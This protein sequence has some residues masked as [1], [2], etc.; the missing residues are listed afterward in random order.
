MTNANNQYIIQR[1]L[2]EGGMGTVYLAEDTM[3]ER[4]VA[5]KELNKSNS[6]A[7][8]PFGNRFQQEA[9]ALARLN[10]PNITHLYS[11]LPKDDTWWMVMEYVQG[12]TLEEWLHI[13]KKMS[14]ALACSIM[15]QIL[16][17]LHHAHRKGIIHRDLKPA[18]VMISEDG[19]V[20]I[21]DFGIARI[22]NSQR[23]TQLGKSVGTLEY[24][25]P[26]QIQGKEGDERTDVYAAGTILYELLCGRPP[27]RAD[28]DYHLMRSKLEEVPEMLE[29]IATAPPA[30]QK[31]IL[32]ALERQPDKRFQDVLGFKSEVQNLYPH[33]L[34]EQAIISGLNNPPVAENQENTATRTITVKKWTPKFSIPTSFNFLPQL[35]FNPRRFAASLQLPKP[36]HLKNIRNLDLRNIKEL[37]LANS[38]WVLLGVIV[39]CGSLILWHSFSD[40]TPQSLVK[41]KDQKP[42]IAKPGDTV[43]QKASG[44]IL[45]NQ[46]M[47]PVPVVN[48]NPAPPT[49]QEKTE[50]EPADTDGKKKGGSSGKKKDSDKKENRVTPP[51]AAENE[52]EPTPAPE[53]KKETRPEHKGPVDIPAGREINMI[54][55]ETISSEDPGRDGDVVRL[56]AG[57]DIQSE[58]RI[59]IKK[60]ALIIGK[61]VDVVPS[62]KRKKGLIGFVAQK[63][64]ASNGT[65]IRLHSERFRLFAENAGMAA[66]YRQGHVFSAKLGRGRLD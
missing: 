5:I 64:E 4:L 34:R 57:E 56:Y 41:D 28:T 16:E 46:F 31:I 66:V 12:K 44:E 20:K 8:E 49:P 40:D 54:L 59:I 21:M 14:P 3:L 37:A 51:P 38:V 36:I 63:V 9:L 24:M 42:V 62:S 19:E 6:S 7:S 32:R 27:F 2:G 33:A 18:N 30:L 47:K 52:E 11:F 15:V 43:R 53:E 22:R 29:G 61:I 55:G 45:D 23:I 17:G 39:F 1:K 50:E 60:G 35:K 25:S 10:H 58:G 48:N 13:N 65:M 26:E